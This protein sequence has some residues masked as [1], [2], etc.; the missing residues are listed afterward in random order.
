MRATTMAGFLA[1]ARIVQRF[2]DCD[3]G[4]A[5]PSS[6][7]AMAWSLANDMLG[8]PSIWR[9]DDDADAGA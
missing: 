9:E 1:K 7:D 5:D 4:C 8:I 2:N 3:F 6:D